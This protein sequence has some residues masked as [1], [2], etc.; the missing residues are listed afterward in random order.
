[1]ATWKCSDPFRMKTQV[2]LGKRTLLSF[3]NKSS[4]DLL[5]EFDRVSRSKV[6]QN[7]IKKSNYFQKCQILYG[8]K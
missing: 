2:E 7:K 5:S 4:H 6:G 8:V 3:S 1:M